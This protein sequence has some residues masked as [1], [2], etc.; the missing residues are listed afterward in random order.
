MVETVIY[1]S[2]GPLCL[3]TELSP[4]SHM[5]QSIQDGCDCFCAFYGS[6]CPN[7]IIR[8][9]DHV[10]FTATF[11]IA[12]SIVGRHCSGLI[13]A[14]EAL[15]WVY[16]KCSYAVITTPK[17]ERLVPSFGLTKQ[18]GRYFWSFL[19]TKPATATIN[20]LESAWF[21]GFLKK[22]TPKHTWLCVGS[23]P[24]RYALQIR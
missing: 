16:Y 14:R 11:V 10:N 4:S 13:C 18:D 17:N 8:Q 6:N 15:H 5:Q 20:S 23:S 9:T 2:N 21:Q 24:V 7:Y 19:A 1:F 3:K 22:K 12:N